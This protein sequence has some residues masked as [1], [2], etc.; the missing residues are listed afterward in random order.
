MKKS[1][2]FLT[3][4][5]LALVILVFTGCQGV[6]PTP[7][8]GA[9]E[10]TGII[11]GRI[12]M[13]LT[14]CVTEEGIL[15]E[16][17]S[18]E[19]CDETED[20][21]FIPNA[22]VE[23]KSAAKGKCDKVIDTTYT[24]ERGNYRF[25]NVKPG[26]YIINVYCPVRKSNMKELFFLKDVADKVSG[27]ALDA[28]IPDCTSTALALVIEK[29][30]DCYNCEDDCFNTCTKIYQLVKEIADDVRK[31]DIDKILNHKKFGKYC[32]IPNKDLVDYVCGFLC[33]TSPGATGG[34][35][36]GGGDDC[37]GNTAPEVLGLDPTF[38]EAG[39]KYVGQVIA[40]DA[41][42]DEMTFAFAPGYTPPD[43]MTISSTGVITW[44]KPIDD[45]ICGCYSVNGATQNT[46]A[47]PKILQKPPCPT[48]Q[49]IVSDRCHSTPAEL[50]LEVQPA[51][52][53]SLSFEKSANKTTYSAVNDEIK[54]T[55]VVT[56]TGNVTLTG[57]TV[58][59]LADFTGKGT[60]PVPSF[61]SSSQGSPAGT[62]KPGEYAT[63]T[64]T[65]KVVQGDLDQGSIY[66]K[67][68][69]DSNETDP[70][71]DNVT[72][73][74]E[75]LACSITVVKE[76]HK[77]SGCDFSP[78]PGSPWS[79]SFTNKP[80]FDLPDGNTW[81]KVFENLTPGTYTIKE[82]ERWGYSCSWN[83]IVSG[84]GGSTSQKI[85]DYEV[86]IDLK[87]G[88]D[89]TVTFTNSKCFK[90]PVPN[91][92]HILVT[93]SGLK[94]L[95]N[96]HPEGVLATMRLSS[97]SGNYPNSYFKVSL[98]TSSGE[99]TESEKHGW[100]LTKDY[101]INTERDYPVVLLP[102]SSYTHHKG[103]NMK[104]ICGILSKATKSY[105]MKQVQNAIWIETNNIP[106]TTKTER[107][108]HKEGENNPV[109]GCGIVAIPVISCT[110]SKLPA[111][112]GLYG[113]NSN[114]S[115]NTS[116][117]IGTFDIGIPVDKDNVSMD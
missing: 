60:T 26:L 92:Q 66:N 41:D 9:T 4:T 105:T 34:G 35:G 86:K 94:N 82:T 76:L 71:T 78:Y 114:N 112:A 75:A 99:F 21:P 48:V 83:M 45:D 70:E 55:Y 61:V 22:R 97:G 5:M 19:Q 1:R 37:A 54:Y 88:D 98:K 69:A 24:D 116:D 25:E 39:K 12:K 23:L 10:D 56:N 63:Y 58:T 74:Y 32:D 106:G 17:S 42:G 16:G 104:T 62:L 77:C 36:G 2:I 110:P 6:V 103:A 20:W 117:D 93:D 68:K 33:C 79:F 47:Q 29:I 80:S 65:Y 96:S 73:D 46:N 109:S 91:N 13:P 102:L 84:S 15:E 90:K 28:G 7:S 14:C 53:A 52:V 89:V 108:L 113:F 85:S 111:S 44:D 100:C 49:I 30:N 11:F 59:E 50:C 72:V 87:A 115:M 31:V 81:E 57:V 67:A 107:D 40:Q 101:N 38:A 43:S 27:Q 64:A 18:D 8:P 95:V 51:P 3:I